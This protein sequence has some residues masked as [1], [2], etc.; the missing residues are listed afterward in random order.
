MSCLMLILLFEDMFKEISNSMDLY[1]EIDNYFQVTG[2][3]GMERILVGLDLTKGM[4]DSITI[5]KCPTLF[6]YT[7]NYEGAPLKCG[8]C[9]EYGYLVRD[10]VVH[11]P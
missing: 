5:R 7:M 11:F 4:V 1:N 6:Q 3:T 10:S 2:Y 8:R 9:H